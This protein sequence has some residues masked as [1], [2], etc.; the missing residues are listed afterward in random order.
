MSHAMTAA[1]LIELLKLAPHPEG[2]FF[3]ETFRSVSPVTTD[4]HVEG[5]RS[6]STAIYFLLHT[7]DFSTFHSVRSDEVWHHYM[8]DP[9]ELTLLHADGRGEQVLLG[10]DFR[11]HQRPQYVVEANVLQAAKPLPGAFGFTLCGCT[12][13]P[14]SRVP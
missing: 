8:G 13:A 3:A 9:L 11:S 4:A 10:T 1:E 7:H 6:A 14:G 2:G 5:T 12:V